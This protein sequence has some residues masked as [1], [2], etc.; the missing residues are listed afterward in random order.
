MPAQDFQYDVAFSFVAQDE[1]LATQLAD[2]FEGRLCVFLYSQKQEQLAGTDG[3]KSFNDIFVAQ[4]R[5]VVVLYRDEWG[6]SPWN[7]IE[8]TAIRNRAFDEGYSFVTFIPLDEKPN[9]PKWLPR[10]Q[11]WVGLKRWGIAGAASV[12]DARIQE[13]GG[14]PTEEKLEH[15][16]ARAERVLTFAKTRDTYLGSDAGVRGANVA[17]EALCEAIRVSVP[18]L[19]AAAPSL[20]ITEKHVNRQLVLLSSGPALLVAWRLKYSNTLSESE[21]EVSLWRGHPPFPGVQFR[22]RQSSIADITF[23]ADLA[24]SGDPA[25]TTKSSS[26][27][28][29]LESQ[30]AAEYILNWWLE[31]ALKHRAQP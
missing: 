28:K 13:L 21:L 23:H 25:W 18:S 19:Q 10:S 5:L 22:E 12:I 9:V 30:A 17:F 3:E 29:T 8:E 11:L 27:S 31:K 15:R 26:G 4:S 2:Q 1:G 6:Q 16:A 14:D 24:P 7:R 20:A